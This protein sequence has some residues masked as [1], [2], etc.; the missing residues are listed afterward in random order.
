MTY[1][2]YA[3]VFAYIH[4]SNKLKMRVLESNTSDGVNPII[5]IQFES[6]YLTRLS[7]IQTRVYVYPNSQKLVSFHEL[8]FI[9]IYKMVAIL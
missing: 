7:I 9:I 8:I 6:L 3:P 4:T 2:Y 5:L 1:N